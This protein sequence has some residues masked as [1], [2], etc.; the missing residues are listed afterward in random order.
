M[1]LKSI[2]PVSFGL[3]MGIVYAIVGLIFGILTA[4]TAAS[5][6]MVGGGLGILS[7]IVTPIMMFVIGF[8]ACAIFAL[9]YN[10]VV[11]SI[12]KHGIKV[13]LK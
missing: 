2:D 12:T 5:I 3:I 4:I 11:K 9:I 6:P 13:G 8:I 7:I 10:F 1:E